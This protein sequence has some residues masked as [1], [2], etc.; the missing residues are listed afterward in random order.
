MLDSCLVVGLLVVEAHKALAC[1][2]V[3]HKPF[4]APLSGCIQL[5]HG[6]A[7]VR[8]DVTRHAE[9]HQRCTRLTHFLR[10]H[11]PAACRSSPPRVARQPGLGSRQAAC[12]HC[13]QGQL[14]MVDPAS[15]LLGRQVCPLRMQQRA[16]SSGRVAAS[17]PQLRRR[18]AA[19]AVTRAATP[20]TAT[21]QP[22]TAAGTCGSL[23]IEPRPTW[24]LACLVCLP[25]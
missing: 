3:V 23:G 8:I 9:D 15:S 4:A 1:P 21:S 2:R 25:S 24:C 6:R 22:S 10:P 18:R 19:P 11:G 16:F 12:G 20:A 13:P 17:G 14:T 7:V 5:Q